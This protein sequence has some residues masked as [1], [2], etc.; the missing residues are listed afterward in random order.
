MSYPEKWKGLLFDIVWWGII[1]VGVVPA[2]GSWFDKHG[3]PS[4][5]G[6]FAVIIGTGIYI[7]R[8]AIQL[9]QFG[10]GEVVDSAQ[11]QLSLVAFVVVDVSIG[12]AVV[13]LCHIFFGGWWRLRSRRQRQSPIAISSDA[14]PDGQHGSWPN[15]S[16]AVAATSIILANFRWSLSFFELS[17]AGLGD[18]FS[19]SNIGWPI[20]TSV[21]SLAMMTNVLVLG[22][23][24]VG[25]TILGETWISKRRKLRISMLSYL[26]VTSSLALLMAR[27]EFKARSE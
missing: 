3:P 24:L 16:L 7:L 17:L 20:H 22:I 27:E 5:G 10:L 13:G 26:G 8:P 18:F 6:V 2:S 4:F 12:I 23:T 14:P 9:F 11:E 25:I 19:G 1:L 15:L 21:K